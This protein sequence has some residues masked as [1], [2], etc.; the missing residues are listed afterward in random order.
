MTLPEST[1]AGL[2]ESPE[3]AQASGS[4]TAGGSALAAGAVLANLLSFGLTV[5]L[6]R[7]YDHAQ[8]GAL[9]ALLGLQFIAAVPAT[10]LQYVVARRTAAAKLPIGRHHRSSLVTSLVL[11]GVLMSIGLLA[12]PIL[13]AALH[14]PAVAVVWVAVLVLPYT[15]NTGQLGTLLGHAQYAR[16]AIAQILMAGGRLTV[17]MVA[18]ALSFGVVGAS[19]AM[20]IGTGLATAAAVPLT[21]WRGWTEPSNDGHHEVGILREM[22]HASGAIAGLAA[23]I[24]IDI[25]LA[26]HYLSAADSGIY[27]LGALFAKA[28]LW[29]AQFIPQLIFPK[30]AATGDRRKLIIGALGVVISIGVAV[31]L[32]AIVLGHPLLKVVSG[33]SDPN[34]AAMLTPRFALLGV[35]WAVCQLVLIAAV[36]QRNP[37]PIRLLWPLLMVEL[38][39]VIAA[40]HGSTDQILN[41]CLISAAVI[42]LVVT[43]AL[44]LPTRRTKVVGPTE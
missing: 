37:W 1:A 10:G 32:G 31:L 43:T 9:A 4:M 8:F 30:L 16:F 11:G 5:V 18:A 24:N 7:F 42:A 28:S 23:L 36:A 26:R 29:G 41:T 22:A 27:A 33:D 17:T 13:G 2:V 6:A 25:L 35:T 21:G 3:V 20:A 38:I 14:V 34:A 19:G 40:L 12:S 44:V 39:V 15:I